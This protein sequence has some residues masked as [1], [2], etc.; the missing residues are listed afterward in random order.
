MCERRK[1]ATSILRAA[2]IVAGALL[3]VSA[4]AFADLVP[5]IP[6]QISLNPSTEPLVL[7]EGGKGA[8][9]VLTVKNISKPAQLIG[10]KNVSVVA[11]LKD[12]TDKSDAIVLPIPQPVSTCPKTITLAFG[13]K[14]T[15]TFTF[16]PVATDSKENLDSGITTV[17]FR[18]DPTLG[19]MVFSDTEI[20]VNDVGFSATPEP[21]T[22]ILLGAGAVCLAA[23]LLLRR[24][25]HPLGS[26]PA[27]RRFL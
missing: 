19:P 12:G 25:I 22:L 27:L 24:G 9:F 14:C 16:T 21:A 15:V 26:R 7:I 6:D 17:R 8:D 4:C 3:L 18:A 23:L 5:A 11:V 13:E 10:I 20:T 1:L 2:P